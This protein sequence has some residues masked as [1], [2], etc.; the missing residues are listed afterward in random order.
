MSQT[1]KSKQ[2]MEKIAWNYLKNL[3]TTCL[4]LF[5]SEFLIDNE[6]REWAAHLGWE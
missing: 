3:C 6:D 5:L 4:Q 1:D 2:S